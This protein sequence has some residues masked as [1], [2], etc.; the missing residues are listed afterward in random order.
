MLRKILLGYVLSLLLLL[1]QQSIAAHDIWHL[2]DQLLSHAKD[3]SSQGNVCEQCLG[4]GSLE[5]CIPATPPAFQ[6]VFSHT[7]CI[8]P[9]AIECRSE[10]TMA[11]SSRAPPTLSIQSDQGIPS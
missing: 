11:Y 9:A 2:H 4:L 1:S 6:T 8:G 5:S 7:G 10:R 3:Q